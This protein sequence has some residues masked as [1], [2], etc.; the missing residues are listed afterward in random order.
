MNFNDA[1]VAHTNWK[2]RIKRSIDGQE[3]FDPATVSKDSVCEL[4]KWIYGEGVKYVSL[5]EFQ[6]MKQKHAQFHQLAGEI[7]RKTAGLPREQALALLGF[8]SAYSAASAACV[9]AITA[10]QAKVGQG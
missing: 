6:L 7:I 10:L 5:P 2:N 8:G 3:Q 1:I 9:N 4:G